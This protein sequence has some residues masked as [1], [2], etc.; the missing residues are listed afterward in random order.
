MT[1]QTFSTIAD[2]D[3][4]YAYT[5]ATSYAGLSAAAGSYDAATQTAM[6]APQ[7]TFASPNYD[8]R[9]AFLRWDTS[10]LPD[11]ATINS[12]TLRIWV[13]LQ[14]ETDPPRNLTADWFAWDLSGTGH[15][16]KVDGNSAN[17]TAGLTAIS[18]YALSNFSAAASTP[19]S[20]DVPI[21]TN[22]NN[23]NKGG[24]TYL[25]LHI[26]GGQPTGYNL[27]TIS[28]V[29]HAT[30]PEP[31]LIVDYTQGTPTRIAP[32]AILSQTNLTGTVSAIQDDPD[33]ETGVWLTAP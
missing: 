1:L 9:N 11:A 5:Q 12:V 26:D 28:S 25:R 33:A 3:D 10:A 31:Q 22:L 21:T 23:V 19:G 6:F 17:F 15:D 18:G 14:I 13:E 4:T 29:N 20:Y 32:D 2:N 27:L 16:L 30:N 24:Y 8:V 7:R